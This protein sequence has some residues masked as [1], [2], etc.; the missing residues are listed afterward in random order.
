MNDPFPVIVRTIE[1]RRWRHFGNYAP[2]MQ[3]NSS[4]VTPLKVIHDAG[5]HLVLCRA[6]AEGKH[7]AKSPYWAQWNVQRPTLDVCSAHDGPLGI[8]PYSLGATA[9]DVDQGDW[10]RLPQS[11]VNYR[12]RRKGGRHL[13]YADD[14][15]RGNSNWAAEDCAGEVRGAKGYL[16]LWDDAVQRLADALTGPRQLSLFP[17]P[18]ELLKA[19]KL[20]HFPAAR[21]DFVVG[22]SLDLETV[23]RG[24]R[25]NSLF[26][27]TRLWAYRAVEDHRDGPLADWIAAVHAFTHQNNKR[28]PVPLKRPSC[29]QS[30]AYSVATWVWSKYFNHSKAM[31]SQRGI[32]SGAARRALTHERDKA[33]IQAVS[34]GRTMRDVGAEYGISARAVHWILSRGVT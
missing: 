4:T 18:V 21:V 7:R 14:Q 2:E 25:N 28:F 11:W 6:R 3:N 26:D 9:L 27:V 10:K 16:C 23:Q 29:I 20:L 22:Q 15:A 24:A 32:K 1:V 34:E 12:T 31:Q 8:I 5:A 30:T 19:G 33:I 17:F 13:Y